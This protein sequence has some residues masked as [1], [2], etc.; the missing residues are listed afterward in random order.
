MPPLTRRAVLSAIS[1]GLVAWQLDRRGAR[2]LVGDWLQ[3]GIRHDARGAVVSV[4]GLEPAVAQ[5]VL[6]PVTKDSALPHGYTP[7]DLVSA[8]A[9]GIRSA[10]VQLIRRLVAED[11]SALIEAAAHDGASVYVGSGFRSEAYQA[12]VFAAQTARWG[13]AELANRYSAQPGHSQHQ[14]G[15]T[16]DFTDAFR[17]FR[18]SPAA[19]WLQAHAHEFGFVLP[20]TDASQPMT[21]YVSEPWHARWVGRPFAAALQSAN[22]QTWTDSSADDALAAV[23]AAI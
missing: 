9:A 14:L 7:S 19:D 1:L 23:H 13:S 3:D 17:A 5:E 21:G 8:N 4:F 22:Y 20:Y 15:T 2:A 12:S 10:G 18:D 16:I 11:T 6:L